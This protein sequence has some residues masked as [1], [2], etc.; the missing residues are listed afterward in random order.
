ML[1]ISLVS[2]FYHGLK[3]LQVF[4]LIFMFCCEWFDFSEYIFSLAGSF[5]IR[6]FTLTTVRRLEITGEFLLSYNND[7][8]NYYYSFKIFPRF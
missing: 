3:T 1:I 8:N 2:T 4:F 5:E 7:N 6:G